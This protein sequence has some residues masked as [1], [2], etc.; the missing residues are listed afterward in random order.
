MRT[1]GKFLRGKVFEIFFIGFVFLSIFYVSNRMGKLSCFLVEKDYKKVILAFLLILLGYMFIYLKSKNNRKKTRNLYEGCSV[2][3]CFLLYLTMGLWIYDSICW[4]LH[5]QFYEGYIFPVLISV[6]IVLYGFYH[7]KKIYRKEYDISLGLIKRMKIVLLSDIHVG[8][9]VDGKQLKKIVSEVN[10]MEADSIWIAG[11]L[12]DVDA[13]DYCDLNKISSILKKLRAKKG[14]YAC[15]GNHDPNSKSEKI[16]DFYK[17]TNIQ[18]IIDDYKKMDE[19]T[20]IARDDITT[21]VHRKKLSELMKDINSDKPCIVM[22]HNPLGILEAIENNVDLIV[23]GHTH[24]GQFFPANVFTKL[25]YGKRGYYGY[26]KSDNTQSIVSS[27][28]GFF[29]M[30]MRIGSNSEIVIINID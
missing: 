1:F 21:N 29:Q 15:L 30:P 17:K 25:A 8:T 26:S 13:F 12:F 7:A 4:F 27:G 9:F 11:D 19:F 6:V 23:C 14:I 10:S 3:V 16:K 24:K 5:I 2:I 18:L 22:D 28:V 20:I